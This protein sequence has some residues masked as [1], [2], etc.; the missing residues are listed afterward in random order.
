MNKQVF[1]WRYDFCSPRTRSI[2]CETTLWKPSSNLVQRQT[3]IYNSTCDSCETHVC[4][5]ALEKYVLIFMQFSDKFCVIL[6]VYFLMTSVSICARRKLAHSNTVKTTLSLPERLSSPSV[7]GF[8]WCSCYSIFNF[9]Y[10]FCRSL[11]VLLSFFFWSLCCLFFDIQILITPL[12]S[13]NSS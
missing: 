1:S 8:Q 9:M 6:S 12:V 7:F 11:F 3:S 4:K 2:C 5:H 13:S 10:M